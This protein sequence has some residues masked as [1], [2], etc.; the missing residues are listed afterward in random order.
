[1]GVA[2]AV[3]LLPRHSKARAA[4]LVA[5]VAVIVLLLMTGP[6]L[7]WPLLVAAAALLYLRLARRPRG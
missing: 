6:Y 4:A 5:Q 7:V 3:R 1:V 2:A